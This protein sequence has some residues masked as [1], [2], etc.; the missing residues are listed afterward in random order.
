LGDFV[1]GYKQWLFTVKDLDCKETIKFKR[2]THWTEDP[3][4]DED[5]FVNV[6]KKACGPP[7][8][9][10]EAGMIQHL[11]TC[12]CVA[13]ETP[14]GELFEVKD[15][16]ENLLFRADVETD[17]TVRLMAP[18]QDDYKWT[19]P[20]YEGTGC[21]TVVATYHDPWARY[22]QVQLKTSEENCRSFLEF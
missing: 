13:Y 21:I 18:G 14:V 2:S 6:T 17:F 20:D 8:V 22:R 19:E 1:T 4:I 15:M 16:T 11:Y 10:C 3:G 9:P 7:T 12:D 5:F